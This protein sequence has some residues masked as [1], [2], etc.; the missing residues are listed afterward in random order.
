MKAVVKGPVKDGDKF[1]VTIEMDAEAAQK[2]EE[3]SF[4]YFLR[5]LVEAMKEEYDEIEEDS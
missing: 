1:L 2:A 4:I 5:D 3:C